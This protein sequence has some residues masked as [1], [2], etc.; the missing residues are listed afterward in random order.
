M[1]KKNT[2]DSLGTLVR[3]RSL[4]VDRLQ[5][6]MTT[7][8]ATRTRYQN[9]LARMDS[10]TVSSGATGALP[11]VLA[12]NCG[13]YK[14]NVMAMADLHRTDLALHEA[15][16][17]VSQRNLTTAWTKR[18]LLGKVLEQQET[19]LARA[20]DRVVRKREDDIATQSWMAGRTA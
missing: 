2:I 19:Q 7:Q 17:A 5:A 9:N 4:D 12:L 20:Q 16:M 14:Q 10:L 11:P 3:L 13:A 6:D 18:E 15:N 8:E 1:S